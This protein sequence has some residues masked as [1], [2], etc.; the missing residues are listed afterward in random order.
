MRAEVLGLQLHDWTIDQAPPGAADGGTVHGES[1]GNDAS[2]LMLDVLNKE[3]EKRG[4]CFVRYADDYNIY[5]RRRSV[6][7]ARRFGEYRRRMAA[8]L[9]LSCGMAGRARCR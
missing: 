1:A 6:R 2:N 9:S 5:R 8:S 3:L 4:H 7:A